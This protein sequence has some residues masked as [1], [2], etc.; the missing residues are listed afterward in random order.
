MPPKKAKA[1]NGDA[2]DAAGG[3]SKTPILPSFDNSEIDI[4]Q[5]F[6]W[7]PEN[8]LR[9]TSYLPLSHSVTGLI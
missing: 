1:A 2:G 4:S 3:V 8:D 5:A 6:R 7:T 9:V